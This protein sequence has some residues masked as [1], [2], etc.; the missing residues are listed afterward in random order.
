MNKLIKKL[1][2]I[3]LDIAEARLNLNDTKGTYEVLQN[4]D[5]CLLSATQSIE[6]AIG[7]L[8][9]VKEKHNEND[10]SNKEKSV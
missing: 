9:E 2:Y 8:F 1:H 3:S 5:M 4:V 6:S 10:N 7:V